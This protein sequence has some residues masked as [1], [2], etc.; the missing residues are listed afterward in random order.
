MPVGV[1]PIPQSMDEHKSVNDWADSLLER[2]RSD[3]DPGPRWFN[4]DLPRAYAFL[5]AAQAI[6][7]ILLCLGGLALIGIAFNSG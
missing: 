5:E 7:L 4:R 6:G 1:V 3:P 2:H